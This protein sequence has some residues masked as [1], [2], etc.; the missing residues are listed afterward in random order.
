MT[1][2]SAIIIYDVIRQLSIKLQ[3]FQEAT[4]PDE[5]IR[6]SCEDRHEST[7]LSKF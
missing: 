1:Y 7:T 3:A 4:E 5:D 2:F 6:G